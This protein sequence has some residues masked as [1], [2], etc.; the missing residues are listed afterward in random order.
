MKRLFIISALFIGYSVSGMSQS[1]TEI[2]EQVYVISKT[3]T[4]DTSANIY[5]F[6]GMSGRVYESLPVKAQL[7][8]GEAL[9]AKE[10]KDGAMDDIPAGKT[11]VENER[12]GLLFLKG[13][14]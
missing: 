11:I 12:T 5:T 8:I 10:V 9:L 4:I 3:A 1:T 13:K 14:N 7:Q 6:R 2:T